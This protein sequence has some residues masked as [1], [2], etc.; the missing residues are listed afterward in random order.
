MI[1]V[2]PF[3]VFEF[4]NELQEKEAALNNLPKKLKE[5]W[6]YSNYQNELRE[7]SN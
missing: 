5:E 3:E 6:L 2:W 7:F 4:E 1:N